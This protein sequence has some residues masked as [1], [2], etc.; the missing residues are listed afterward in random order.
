MP[1]KAVL[2][3]I[4][5]NVLANQKNIPHNVISR[6]KQ[7]ITFD[8]S[9]YGRSGS[10]SFGRSPTRLS[11]SMGVHR[12]LLHYYCNLDK[13]HG[14]VRGPVSPRT[15][16]VAVRTNTKTGKDQ[17]GIGATTAPTPMHAS[18]DKDRDPRNRISRASWM[19]FVDGNRCNGTVDEV[20]LKTFNTLLLERQAH[21]TSHKFSLFK[22]ERLSVDDVAV[23]IK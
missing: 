8:S 20:L 23:L 2:S 14:T 10:P 4:S 19:K 13:A 22:E 6:A 17:E 1:H 5:N 18:S 11:Q 9:G 3:H 7:I 12:Q 15:P 21:D 16:S